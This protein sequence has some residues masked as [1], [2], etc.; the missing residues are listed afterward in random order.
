MISPSDPSYKMTRLIKQGRL[1]MNEEFRQFA[2][3]IDKTYGVTTMNI[4]YDTIDNNKKPRLNIIFEMS[5]EAELFMN[6]SGFDPLKQKEIASRFEMDPANHQYNAHDIFVIFSA[7]EPIA[8]I[9]VYWS[10][11]KEEFRKLELEL[12]MSELWQIRSNSFNAPT[13]FFYTPEQMER[14]SKDGT[15]ERLAG[16][17]FR[18][19]KKYDEFDYF[20]ENNF[21]IELDSKENFEGFYKS[22]WFYYDRR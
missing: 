7:F 22:N 21:S 20:K 17:C 3:W 12:G 4:V 6:R 13:F 5:S 15:M 16:L 8:K 1:A 11:P 10:I 18:L 9:D 2:D 14:Y 19:V